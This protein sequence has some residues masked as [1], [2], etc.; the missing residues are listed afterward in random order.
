MIIHGES[1]DKFSDKK[2]PLIFSLILVFFLTLIFLAKIFV[3]ITGEPI[4]E[5]KK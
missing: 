3:Y 2:Y 5:L 1:T 4:V